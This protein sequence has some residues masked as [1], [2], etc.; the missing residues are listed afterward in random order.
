MSDDTARAVG[1]SGSATVMIAGKECTARPLSVRELAE[2][3]RIC[4]DEYKDNYLATISRNI[5]RLPDKTRRNA[6]ME[7]E[8]TKAAG[9]VVRDLPSVSAYDAGR[10]KMTPDL[11]LW[12]KDTFQ[13]N[14]KTDTD[15]M[16][17]YASS[18]LDQGMMSP[19]AYEE[20]TGIPAP[21]VQ[22]GYVNWWITGS[23]DGMLT[24]VWVCF[25]DNG[26]TKDE[27]AAALS[28]DRTTLIDMVRNI[29]KLSV[30]EVGNG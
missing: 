7:E 18:A 4:V 28:K 24:M 22:I 2:V 29:E 16:A 21:V 9:W 11:R 15:Q 30:P 5:R 6:Y 14:G 12:L 13:L 27:V 20:M 19:E 25:K 1:A 8:M 3:E 17:Q 10:V 26:V 23:T